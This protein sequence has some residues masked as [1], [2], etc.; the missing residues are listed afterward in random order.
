MGSA[1][2][3]EEVIEGLFIQQI[4]HLNSSAPFVPVAVKNIV[5]SQCD[6]KQVALL[7]SLWIVVVVLGE[8]CGY[9]NQVGGELVRGARIEAGKSGYPGPD[10]CG[11]RSFH[12]AAGKPRL[13][14]L[15]SG[16]G[17][18]ADVVL[19][20]YVTLRNGNRAVDRDGRVGTACGK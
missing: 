8:R 5:M 6:V 1:K 20:E 13:E 7:N 12:A 16:E 3:R 18:S 15:I 17:Q 11:W 2:R 9:L 14:L 4:N 19:Q 10:G